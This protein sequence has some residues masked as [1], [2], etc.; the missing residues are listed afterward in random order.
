MNYDRGYLK[1]AN[2]EEETHTTGRALCLQLAFIRNEH[3][4]KPEHQA[5][6]AHIITEEVAWVNLQTL[7]L[8]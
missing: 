1:S 8:K 4:D 3:R 5:T 6:Y 7:N 2:D